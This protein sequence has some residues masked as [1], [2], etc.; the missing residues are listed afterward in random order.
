MILHASN[1]N[2]LY[3]SVSRPSSKIDSKV[4]PPPPIDGDVHT[5]AQDA[6]RRQQ[7]EDRIARQPGGPEAIMRFHELR[8]TMTRIKE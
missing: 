7:L 6:V 1:P 3:A 4:S 2:V 5:R 8:R